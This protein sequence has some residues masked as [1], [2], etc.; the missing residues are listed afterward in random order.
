MANNLRDSADVFIPE[1]ANPDY[2]EMQAAE[3]LSRHFKCRVEFLIPSGSYKQK[4]PDIVMNGVMWEIKT[5]QTDQ[6]KKIESI[7]SHAKHQ[8]TS[9]VID[10]RYSKISD[11]KM[12][13]I[14][15]KF[16][17]IHHTLRRVILITKA[18]NVL[19]FS[20]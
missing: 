19:E 1:Q 12:R 3:I 18:K 14:V 15:L 8:S 9:V 16:I 20:R 13:N 4:T 11:E 6:A 5:P 2:R 17:Q 10:N 7:L